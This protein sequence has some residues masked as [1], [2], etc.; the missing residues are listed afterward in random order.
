MKITLTRVIW[1]AFFAFATA[2]SSF[3]EQYQCQ[4]AGGCAASRT[5]GGKTSTVVFRKGDIVDTDAGWVVTTELG[6]SKVAKIGDR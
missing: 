2:W 6:W 1:T 4:D 3:G 5:S